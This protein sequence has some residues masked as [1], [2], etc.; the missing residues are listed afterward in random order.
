MH[1]VLLDTMMAT[2][3]TPAIKTKSGHLLDDNNYR[4]IA[5]ITVASKL[6]ESLILPRATTFLTT[7]ANKFG[8]KK[9]HV[10]EMLIIFVFENILRTASRVCHNVGCLQRP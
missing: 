8:F 7:Y 2:I 6:F 3:T 9:Q 1:G 4:P 10:T 5:L